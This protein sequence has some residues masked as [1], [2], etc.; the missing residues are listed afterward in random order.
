MFGRQRD[1]AGILIEPSLGNEIDVDDEVAV[2]QF[3][4]KIWC[5]ISTRHPCP[6]HLWSNCITL[7]HRPFVEEANRAAPA[8][9]R[10]FKEMIL[11]SSHKKPLPRAAKSTVL[12][13]AVYKIYEKEIDQM[14]VPPK[15]SIGHRPGF[16]SVTMPSIL[17]Q[18]VGL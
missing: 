14:Y 7:A 2:S 9:S 1:Q 15:L 18:A 3:R 16:F 10:I 8:Y 11:I 12:R 4:N 6:S 13:K 5:V 17:M